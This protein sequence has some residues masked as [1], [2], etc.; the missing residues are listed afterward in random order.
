MGSS[1]PIVVLGNLILPPFCQPWSSS[2]GSSKC[3]LT[4]VGL[5]GFIY[6]HAVSIVQNLLNMT[7]MM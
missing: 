3:T 6:Q 7:K 2:Y 5:V 4:Y 1:G